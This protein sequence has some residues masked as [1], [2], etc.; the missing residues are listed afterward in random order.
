MIMAITTPDGYLEKKVV[1]VT[2]ALGILGSE[3][4]KACISEGATVIALD[5]ALNPDSSVFEELT[6]KLFYIRCDVSSEMSVVSAMHEIDKLAPQ[7]DI[8]INN[9]ATKSTSLES[10]FKPLEDYSLQTWREV[11]SVNIDGMFLMLKYVLP[12]MTV[13]GCGTIVQMSSIYGMVG[14]DPKIYEGSSYLGSA[15]NLPAVYSASKSAVLGLTR[16]V[17]TQYGGR[18]IRANAV[19]P[20]G[21]F[22][23]QNDIFKTQY[24][25]KVPMGRMANCEEIVQAVLFLASDRSTY[26]NGQGLCVDGGLTA[27]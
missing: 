3:I 25:S 11:M 21:V 8:L 9:A 17:A 23:G 15:I 18:G 19:L 12:R 6:Q 26:I 27:W 5:L 10:F 1:V 4:V 13:S 16:W 20:G 2:G 14:P 24:S 7:I 22:S